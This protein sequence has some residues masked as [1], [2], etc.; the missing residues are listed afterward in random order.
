MVLTSFIQKKIQWIVFLMIIGCVPI[1]VDDGFRPSFPFIRTG[2]LALFFAEPD[3]FTSAQLGSKVPIITG[4]GLI[5]VPDHLDDTN[6]ADS[7]AVHIFT[8]TGKLVATF[9]GQAAGDQLGS[10]VTSLTNGNFIISAP[11]MDANGLNGAGVQILVN[12]TT[13]EEIARVSGDQANDGIGASGIREAGNGATYVLASVSDDDGATLNA[14]SIMIVSASTGAV[15]NTIRGGAANDALDGDRGI[16]TYSTT[17]HI[18]LID[19]TTQGN[20]GAFIYINGT[21]GNLIGQINGVN[22]NDWNNS[23]LGNTTNE[24]FELLN[25][26]LLLY[27][28]GMDNGAL[29]VA[30]ACIVVNATTGLEVGRISGAAANEQL[31]FILSNEIITNGN[32]LCP[33]PFANANV[34]AVIYGNGVTATEINRITGGSVGDGFF[35]FGVLSNGNWV[36]TSSFFDGGAGADTG[37][38]ITVNGTT[39]VEL[40]RVEGGTANDQLGNSNQFFN[41]GNNNFLVTSS[42]ADNGAIVN[43]GVVI[44]IDG[45]TGL[46]IT[47]FSGSTAN[48]NFG[49][50]S[51]GVLVLNNNNFVICAPNFDSGAIV[52]AGVAILVNGSTGVE[53]S[54]LTGTTASDQICSG[55]ATKMNNNNFIVESPLHDVN[56]IVNAGSF[57]LIDGDTGVVIGQIAGD[58]ANDS[59]GNANSIPITDSDSIV[60]SAPNNDVGTIVDAGA[61]IVMDGVSGTEVSRSEGDQT[62]DNIGTGNSVVGSKT[63]IFLNQNDDVAGVVDSGSIL[64]LSDL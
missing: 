63:L 11:L 39:G 51:T 49:T 61:L 12:G 15:L 32:F 54:R 60:L 1:A 30:G 22:G 17:G 19:R 48:D 35:R 7:G 8:T 24:G 20:R 3:P 29:N 52:D 21:T 9:R 53:I 36:I 45:T 37:V 44:M 50:A 57:T 38:A 14:G 25:G 10:T 64:V 5:V 59:F 18:G 47:R 6:G 40:N 56:G 26:N 16:V 41:L 28:G 33:G 23:K 4:G 42:V 31:G 13:G 62:N 43:A 58:Q 46:E 55:G 2:P 27:A 34:S